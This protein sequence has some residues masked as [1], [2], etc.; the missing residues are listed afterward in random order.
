[1][2]LGE[3]GVPSIWRRVNLYGRTYNTNTT[4]MPQIFHE[5]D[6]ICLKLPFSKTSNSGNFPQNARKKQELSM[7]RALVARMTNSVSFPKNKKA[8]P[9]IGARPHS[10]TQTGEGN[11]IPIPLI[12][13]IP[14]GIAGLPLSSSGSSETIASVVSMRPAIEAAF[15][16]AVRVT[17]AGSITPA[18]TRSS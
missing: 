4:K 17:L 13:P 5:S 11:Y 1:M 6:R 8:A 14:P 3:L 16:N 12:P 10:D 15:C 2:L 9:L 18:F 7:Q